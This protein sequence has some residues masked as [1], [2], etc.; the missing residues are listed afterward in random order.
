MKKFNAFSEVEITDGVTTY[1]RKNIDLTKTITK[2][3][4]EAIHKTFSLCSI[5]A[6]ISCMREKINTAGQRRLKSK[7]TKKENPAIKLHIEEFDSILDAI[8]FDDIKKTDLIALNRAYALFNHI[9][10]IFQVDMAANTSRSQSEKARKSRGKITDDGETISNIINRLANARDALGDPVPATD[11]WE[12]LFAAL[13]QAGVD[14]KET[15]NNGEPR[16]TF[17]SYT[18]ANGKGKTI[19]RGTFDNKISIYRKKLSR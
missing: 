19:K 1:Y 9:M 14:P 15:R 10:A 17:Y 3:D 11:L 2:D 7:K 16:K 12:P 8:N 5:P 4:M 13:Q 18:T 6:T